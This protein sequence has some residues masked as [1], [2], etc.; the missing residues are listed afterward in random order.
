MF[1][2][3]AAITSTTY[4]ATPGVLASSF[5]SNDTRAITTISRSSISV[6]ASAAPQAD[7]AFY[8]CEL[9]FSFVPADSSHLVSRPEPPEQTPAPISDALCANDSDPRCRMEQGTT[10]EEAHGK[11]PKSTDVALPTFAKPFVPNTEVDGPANTS[12]AAASRSLPCP[13][14]PP[15]LSF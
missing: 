12:A 6:S 14:R 5:D 2:L 4:L 3:W 8:A 9:T 10:P 11:R 7:P 13:F 1:W 15:V